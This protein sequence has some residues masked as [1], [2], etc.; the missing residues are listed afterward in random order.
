MKKPFRQAQFS[1]ENLSAWRKTLH[2]A[3]IVLD[4]DATP[5][6][7]MESFDSHVVE[8]GKR[9]IALEKQVADEQARYRKLVDEGGT[10]AALEVEKLRLE[11]FKIELETEQLKHTVPEPTQVPPEEPSIVEPPRLEASQEDPKPEEKAHPPEP[12]RVLPTEPDLPELPSTKPV[13]V[14]MSPQPG[15]YG[16]VKDERGFRCAD[17]SCYDVVAMFEDTIR[18]HREREHGDKPRTGLNLWT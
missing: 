1:E 4:E 16:I 7:I 18:K 6:R 3:G 14:V 15:D 11:R 12:E 9:V 5:K 2:D 17:P 13:D 10:Y 8:L